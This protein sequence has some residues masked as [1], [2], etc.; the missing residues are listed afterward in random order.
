[1]LGKETNRGFVRNTE[2]P[3][4]DVST[5]SKTY[6]QTVI[7]TNIDGCEVTDTNVNGGGS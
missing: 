5:R 7:K 3:I 6:R 4:Q 2:S 1:M